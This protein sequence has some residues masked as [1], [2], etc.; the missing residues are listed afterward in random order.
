LAAGFFAA[1]FSWPPSSWPRSFLAAAFLAGR[2]F[3]AG[4]AF[5]ASAVL[6][7]E[8]SWPASQCGAYSGRVRQLRPCGQCRKRC[9]GR[10]LGPRRSVRSGSRWSS[11]RRGSAGT[12][13]RRR[14]RGLNVL[15]LRSAMIS[16][17]R[18]TI[19]TIGDTRPPSRCGNGTPFLNSPTLGGVQPGALGG[20]QDRKSL[21]GKFLPI[22]WQALATAALGVLAVDERRVHHLP[23][24][25]HQ[26]GPSSSSFLPTEVKLSLDQT[27]PQ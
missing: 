7:G 4:A 3:L 14:C 21:A 6:G 26:R 1:A 20:D 11:R 9:R 18:M 13:R 22:L 27:C 25:A 23:D 12:P 15:E 2:L 8:P 19:G 5:V 17:L 10:A 16:A 24:G